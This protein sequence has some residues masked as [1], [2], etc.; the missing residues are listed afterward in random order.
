MNMAVVPNTGNTNSLTIYNIEAIQD[1]YTR[2]IRDFTSYL[3]AS[4]QDLNE[5]SIRDYIQDLNGSHY[6]VN[7][8]RIKRQAVKRR[9]SQ[10]SREMPFEARMKINAFLTDIDKDPET[11]AP[12]I[13]ATGIT[14]DMYLTHSEVQDLVEKARSER[15]KLFIRFLYKTGC[16]VAEMASIRLSDAKFTDSD[17][18]KIRILGKGSKERFLQVPVTFWNEITTTFKG[19]VYLF[20]TGNGRAYAKE[21]ISNQIKK[22]G[23]LIKKNIS[24]HVLRH[25]FAMEMIKR[26]PYMID[27]VSRYLGHSDPAITLRMYC[28]NTLSTDELF[29][30]DI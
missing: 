28:H 24:A 12:K 10:L 8:K 4:N 16:R 11:R 2:H 27:A 23:K 17:S 7:T 14:R 25:S 3:R 21:Y 5:D 29:D 13:Q 1:N 20:E 6:S 22:Q 15:Q 19:S 26:N 9:V 18:V 30:L